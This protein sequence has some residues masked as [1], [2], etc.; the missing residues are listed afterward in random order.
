MRKKRSPRGEIAARY[1]IRW[2]RTTTRPIMPDCD[3]GREEESQS[4][5]H[6]M[7]TSIAII[8]KKKK[9]DREDS[10]NFPIKKEE[11]KYLWK[12]KHLC[13]WGRNYLFF[14][15]PVFQT[16]SCTQTDALGWNTRSGFRFSFFPLFFFGMLCQKIVKRSSISPPP[17]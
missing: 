14:F 5:S 15:P 11:E 16:R 4:S 12:N 3:A 13:E 8:S 9:D 7:I 6:L 10:G 2:R 17:M 1:R